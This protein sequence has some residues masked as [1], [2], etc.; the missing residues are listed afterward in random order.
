M[1]VLR[2]SRKVIAAKALPAVLHGKVIVLCT[3]LLT[4]LCV[5]PGAAVLTGSIG[6]ST[7][8]VIVVAAKVARGASDADGAEK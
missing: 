5:V 1:P 2:R 3:S 7:S 4:A 8:L 6:Q